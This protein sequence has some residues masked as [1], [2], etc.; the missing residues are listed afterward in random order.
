MCQ[1]LVFSN[2]KRSLP[3]PNNP[4]WQCAKKNIKKSGSLGILPDSS[5]KRDYYATVVG[6]ESPNPSHDAIE[7]RA[8]LT[9]DLT[10][11]H[12]PASSVATLATVSD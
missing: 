1:K 7:L 4:S 11:S 5:I 12:N 8:E 10:V 3:C 9:Y 6:L 2:Q